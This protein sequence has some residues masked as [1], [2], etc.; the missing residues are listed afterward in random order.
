MAVSLEEYD[1]EKIL[2]HRVV[3]G[4]EIQYFIKWLDYPCD[5]STWEPESIIQAPSM[6]VKYWRSKPAEVRQKAGITTSWFRSHGA[7]AP[8]YKVSKTSTKKKVKIKMPKKR[9]TI[10]KSESS[11]SESIKES[12]SEPEIEQTS[13]SLIFG[14][15]PKDNCF[16][17]YM[18]H[19]FPMW[20][21]Q[22]EDIMGV[23][24]SPLD[25]KLYAKVVDFGGNVSVC[26]THVLREKCP[27]TL[28]DF[29][30]QKIN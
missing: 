29:Y 5:Q 21:A 2:E 4:G 17:C 23:E 24:R 11:K 1:V 16:P 6:L 9:K 30:E 22:I 20:S 15:P 12:E 26:S 3:E 25:G 7:K 28:F 13:P 18:N 27:Q 10:E 8:D 19:D 14:Q